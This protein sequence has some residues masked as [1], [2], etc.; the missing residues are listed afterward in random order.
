MAGNSAQAPCKAV[1]TLGCSGN[2]AGDKNEV[3]RSIVRCA[4]WTYFEGLWAREDFKYPSMCVRHFYNARWRGCV[5][6]VVSF[7]V[8][9]R[10]QVVG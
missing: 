5:F 9:A 1:R 6:C 3:L 4:V 7:R 8:P 10:I 2:L